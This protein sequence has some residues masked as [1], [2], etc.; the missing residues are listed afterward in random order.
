MEMTDRE[1][2]AFALALLC[3]GVAIIVLVVDWQIK[4]EILKQANKV[5][6]D[7]DRWERKYYG[8]IETTAVIH[9]GSGDDRGASGAGGV[10]GAA[11]MEAAPDP[12]PFSPRRAKV[13]PVKR[14]RSV[15]GSGDGS[16][17]I[18]EADR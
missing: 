9:S 1:K 4:N 17:E 16:V 13:A 5:R 10:D 11:G 6:A 8:G 2:P 14:P 18:S 7:I 15:P 12:V 3:L